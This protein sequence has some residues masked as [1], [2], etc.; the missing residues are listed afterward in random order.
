MSSSLAKREVRGMRWALSREALWRHVIKSGDLSVTE[1]EKNG[2]RTFTVRLH[3]SD[4]ES[5]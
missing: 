4:D 3:V 5:A 2:G 1:G